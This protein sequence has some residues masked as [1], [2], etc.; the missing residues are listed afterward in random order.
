MGDAA[1]GTLLKIGDGAGTEAFTTIAQVIDIDGPNSEVAV[2]LDKHHDLPSGVIDKIGGLMDEGDVTFTLAFDPSAVTHQQLRTDQIART[3]RNFNLV[4]TDAG[5]PTT[6]E[7]GALIASMGS[8]KNVE[9][10]IL[11]TVTLA[12]SG[13]VNI[14]P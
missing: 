3:V 14:S 11:G 6:W 4:H 1:Y 5:G 13:A 12:I 2:I 7:F 10:R 9:D 8:T